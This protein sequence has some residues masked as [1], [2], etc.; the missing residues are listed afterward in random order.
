MLLPYLRVIRYQNLLLIAIMQLIIRYGFLKQ[1]TMF[2]ALSDFQYILLVI[3]TL[4]LAGAGYVIN[5][6]FDQDTDSINKPS[7]RII[8]VAISESKAYNYYVALNIT[9]VSIGFYLSNVIQKP[10]FA[11]I[12]ILI[13]ASLYFY[14]TS[15]KQI[16]LLGNIL[17]AAQLSLSVIIIGIFDLFPAMYVDNADQ[18]RLLFKILLDFALFAFIIN[19]IREIIKDIEDVKGDYNQGM[20]TL[21]I[22][23]GV[24]RT[25]KV[26]FAIVIVPILLIIAYINNYLMENQLYYASIYGLLFVLG[27]LLYF[28]IKN[29]SA[30]KKEHFT[31]LSFVLKV[32][33]FFGILSIA[34]ISLNINY[35]A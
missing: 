12:F 31:H 10:S 28:W 15:L 25:S 29:F 20:K 32:I 6:I 2:L 26:I 9:G 14:A 19:F 34:I 35:N 1:H 27:P 24:E 23:L 7:K 16:L 11:A 8:G 17:V 3:T 4:L 33:I 18:M 21:P 13:A 22:V 30:K 5:D